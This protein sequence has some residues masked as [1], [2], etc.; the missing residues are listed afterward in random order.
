MNG[1][2][3]P[4]TYSG[5]ELRHLLRELEEGR[6]L[7]CPRCATKLVVQAPVRSD[8]LLIH[9][10]YCPSCMHCAILRSSARGRV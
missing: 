8:D 3:T 5:K 7:I 6:T 4:V 9:E 10:T 1:S 2:D